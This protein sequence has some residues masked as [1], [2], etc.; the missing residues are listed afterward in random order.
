[1][2]R[3]RGVSCIM[4]TVRLEDLA[5]WRTRLGLRAVEALA[6]PDGREW[7]PI[8]RFEEANGAQD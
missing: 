5:D 2:V 8:V 7:P 4:E 1:M 6:W 3:F